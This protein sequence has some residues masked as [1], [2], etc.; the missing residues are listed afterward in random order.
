M[1]IVENT[2]AFFTGQTVW[3]KYKQAKVNKKK[4]RIRSDTKGAAFAAFF[5]T[6]QVC[7]MATNM[8]YESKFLPLEPKNQ[9]DARL[10]PDAPIWQRAEDKETEMLW[11]K[12]T[13]KL[14]DQPP[15]E[16]YDP[17][18]LQF[19]YKMKIKDGDYE[20]GIPKA[21]LVLMGN[22]QYDHEYGETYAPTAKLWVI[23]SLAAI[24]AQEG[25]TLK[26]FDLTGAYLNADMDRE[27]YVQIPGYS[28]P[29]GKALLLK[30]ALYGG[31]S[32]GA[33]YS[34]EIRTWLENYG[35]KACSVDETLFRLDKTDK[36]GKKS[37][38]IVSLYVDDGAC[39]TNDNALYEKFIKDLQGK[40]ELSDVGDLDWHLGIKV[41]QDL[42][43]G[44]VTLDQTSYIDSVVTRFNMEGSKDKYTPMAPHAHLTSDDCPATPNK[45]EVKTYQQLLGCLM[46]IAC[47]T[48]PDISF[49]VNSCAQYMQNPGES[50]FKA[51]K[52]ILRY[53][54]TTRECKLTY[55][56][57]PKEMANV[58][59][60]FVDA[61]HA[62]SAEDRKSVGGY[63]LLLNGAA[64]SWSSKKIKVV[65]ISSFESEWYSASI[66]GCE[67]TV[68]RRMLEE[69]DR[70]QEEPT[71]LFEDNAACIHSSKDNK[72]FGPR[73][74]HIDVRVFKLREFVADGILTL[75]KVCT[76]ANV[77]DCLTKALPREL[78]ERMREVMFGET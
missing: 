3:K 62:G 48:R 24:A 28:I 19:I 14:V 74:K 70:R 61:D 30:K 73:S 22:L 31:K 50:H 59:Y 35:F 64:I 12:G 45:R 32:S 46:Y 75:E 10:R 68:V 49:A 29:K 1:N 76:S 21:R 23:R 63:V 17:I 9:R 8:G 4:F 25:L 55:R 66:C 57:Q 78:V 20:N 43:A 2:K 60:G 47:A 71:K 15:E 54:K 65:A 7:A 77:A 16:E 6:M 53:L 72:E 44:T 37:T 58:L 36:H 26:K 13:F 40:Y 38:L 51:A 52:H 69:I 11:G 18:P 27:V 67:I 33:L 42:E 56:K 34:K 41:T 39:C 5:A